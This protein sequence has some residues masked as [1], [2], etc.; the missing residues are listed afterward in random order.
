M[1]GCTK[2][3]EGHEKLDHQNLGKV[4]DP[5][6]GH[7]GAPRIRPSVRPSVVVEGISLDF[8]EA[9]PRRPRPPAPTRPSDDGFSL[10]SLLLLLLLLLLS[11]DERCPFCNLRRD[12][13]SPS[14]AEFVA[15]LSLYSWEGY[16]LSASFCLPQHYTYISVLVIYY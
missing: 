11:P 13:A 2:V 9:W 7:C 15:A 14:P 6:F 5:L 10:L 3:V 12:A 16:I 4:E 8:G 1:Q